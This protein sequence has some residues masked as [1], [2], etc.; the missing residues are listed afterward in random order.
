MNAVSDFIS[1]TGGGR[2]SRRL[3]SELVKKTSCRFASLLR[4]SPLGL[5]VVHVR[6]KLETTV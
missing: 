6:S 4:G 3:W 2:F 5:A 1:S